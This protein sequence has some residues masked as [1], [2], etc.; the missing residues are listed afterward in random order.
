MSRGRAG[1][2]ELLL[3]ED[4]D[5]LRFAMTGC[6]SRAG[7]SVTLVATGADAVRA[8]RGRRPD[9]MVIDLML[10]DAGGLGVATEIRR[11]PAL[12]SV[13]VLYTTGF[14]SPAVRER[15]APDPVLFK[16]FNTLQLLT[17]VRG[18]L[19]DARPAEPARASESL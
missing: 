9:L 11:D 7:S 6:L 15:L 19:A 13:P 5:E 17:S 8:A 4:D 16:P 10:P 12:R 3:V 18:V 2:V 14:D 1:K